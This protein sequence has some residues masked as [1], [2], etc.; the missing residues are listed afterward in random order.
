MRGAVGVH[1]SHKL[2]FKALK[3]RAIVN[4]M[5]FLC[6]HVIVTCCNYSFADLACKIMASVPKT[7]RPELLSKLEGHTGSINRVKIVKGEDAVITV[8]DDK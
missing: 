5:I 8:S 7:R 4:H 1:S 6:N 2:K 3:P